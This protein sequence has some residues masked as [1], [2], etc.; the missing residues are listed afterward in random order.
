M[1]VDQ[2]LQA[3]YNEVDN[4]VNDA[5]NE[6]E[7]VAEIATP[8]SETASDEV[9]VES[10][11]A[12]SA[13]EEEIPADTEEAEETDTS[14]DFQDLLDEIPSAE[15][16]LKTHNRIANSAKDDLVKYANM[17]RGFR[18]TLSTVGGEEGIKVL[19][20]I[21]DILQR[22]DIGVGDTYEA[23][24]AIATTNP[25]AAFQMLFDGAQNWLFTTENTPEAREMAKYGDAVLAS[26]FGDGVT[27]EKIDKMLMLEKNGY[28]NLDEDMQ[29]LQSE[30]KDSTLF[31]QQQQQ[32]AEQ[33]EKIRE[34]TELVNNPDKIVQ[35][36][37]AT[38]NAVKD[39]ETEL[40]TRITNGVTPFRERGR[41][42][43]ESALTKLTMKAL[44]S[45]LKD[46]GEYKEAVKFVK[47]YGS[48]KQGDVIP[49]P[50]EQKL[51]ALVNKAKGRFGEDVVAI[52]KEL[53]KLAET[54]TNAVVQKE[55]KET[56]P[57]AVAVAPPKRIPSGVFDS[58][59]EAIWAEADAL[60]ARA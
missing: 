42:S 37:V 32:I 18:D 45:E 36:S 6:E 7:Q 60:R 53:R 55:V 51:Y 47:Q 25:P 13:E 4:P 52:N 38:T 54:S 10:V 40:L 17:A 35:Q 9:E 39:F 44:V 43:E 34:L 26:R 3:I 24:A 27:S 41:W 22:P 31:Q 12:E 56:K 11:E 21:A 57:K 8:D 29:L 16:I 33:A 46:S 59:L 1:D 49:F 14:D 48:L 58:D 20:P 19:K 28:I 15:A 50:L 2:D 23:W 5:A 30:G